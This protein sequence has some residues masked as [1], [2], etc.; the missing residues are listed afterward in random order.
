MT[1]SSLAPVVIPIVVAIGLAAW[2]FMVFYADSHP[3][4]RGQATTLSQPRTG[5]SAAAGQRPKLSQ[6]QATPA[7]QAEHPITRRPHQVDEQKTPR[8]A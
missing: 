4:W 6:R 8:A 3:Y 7:R 1:G 5:T 2:I